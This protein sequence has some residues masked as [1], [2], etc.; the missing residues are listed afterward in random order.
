MGEETVH[1]SKSAA[2]RSQVKRRTRSV[3]ASAPAAPETVTPMNGHS[4][5]PSDEDVRV[6]AYHRYLDR[7]AAHG[8]DL[9]DWIEAE[10]DLKK[11]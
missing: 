10:K 6:R 2:P 9:D 8:S 7:G 11:L 3:K 5:D 4:S 1:M